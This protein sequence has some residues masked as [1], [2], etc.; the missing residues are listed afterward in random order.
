MYYVL[1]KDIIESEIIPHLPTAKRGFTTKSSLSEIVNAILYKLK[2]GVQWRLLPVSS[3][4][5]DVVLHYNSVFSHFRKW[6]KQGLWEDIWRKILS[7][8]KEKLDLSSIDLDGSHTPALRGGEK[9]AYQGRKS[10][11]T[12]NSLYLTDRQGIV[13]AMSEP[14]AG[15]HNDLYE[16]ENAM[17]TILQQVENAQ[18]RVDGLFINADGGFDSI[19]LKSIC[20]AKEIHLNVAQNKRNTKLE[21][22]HLMDQE[23][24]KERYMIER[25]NAWLDSFRSILNRFDTT[26]TSWKGF[27][28]LGFIV[29]GLKKILK[30]KKV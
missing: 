10:K 8:Y 11:K 9:V 13:L 30:I 5:S 15:N 19:K 25:T 29:I 23:L 7:K 2:S 16:I 26:T 12:T 24:Y 14:V 20:E 17:N 21:K 22:E 18:I 27:N 4:F 3:L 1:D 6:S 28:F